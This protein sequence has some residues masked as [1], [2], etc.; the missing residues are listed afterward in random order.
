[1]NASQNGLHVIFGTG[2]LGM[3]IAHQLIAQG[4]KVR[5]VNRHNQVHLPQGIV[6]EIGDAT[7][8]SFTQRVCQGAEVIY[9]C[10]GPKYN[11]KAWVQ[12]FPPLQQGILAGA[13]AS[14]AKLIYGDSLY[15]YGKVKEPMHEDLPYAA[16]TN[17][18]KM[19]AA[20]AETLM[21]AHREG[22]A[23]VA[24]AR[25]SDFYG[26]GVLN[27]V[28]GDRVF[29]PAIQGKT[30]EAI[31]NLDLP[32]T[33][34]YIR[35]FARA[36]IILGEREEAIGQ[37]W[38]VPNAPTI[39]TREMLN[40]LFEEL[41]LPAKMNGMGKLMMRIGAVF[42]PEAAES[43]EMMYQF[44]NPFVVDSSKFVRVFGDIA[45]PH[46]EAIRHTSAWYRQH[47]LAQDSLK[48]GFRMYEQPN[49]TTN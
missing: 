9:H 25:S 37:V 18:G 43:I 46:R 8:P 35:D 21:S 24:I 7:N 32:H 47:L 20:L 6:L 15:G 14:G 31:G 33:Y 22:K 10:A 19:R 26:E 36:M 1:M 44:E 11:F 23:K 5:M 27:S 2:A 29:I 39:S 30:A 45:T 49:L 4:K 38:H 48:Q 41:E 34:T 28:F 17:K 16:H 12:E 40:I 13:I 42:I 3:A